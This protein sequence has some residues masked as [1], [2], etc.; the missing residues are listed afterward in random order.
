MSNRSEKTKVLFID[1]E[2][3]VLITLEDMCGDYFQVY[4]AK[5]VIE[6]LRLKKEH[7]INIIYTDLYLDNESGLDLCR[8]IREKDVISI[9]SAFTG[10][11]GVLQL[12]DLRRNGFDDYLLKPFSPSDFL[13]SLQESER[14]MDRWMNSIHKKD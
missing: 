2:E 1:D 9:V 10:H 14:R 7:N 3:D 8:K 6:G 5:T 12:F 13:L 11:V 4:T